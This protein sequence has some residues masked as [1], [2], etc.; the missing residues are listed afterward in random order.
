MACVIRGLI[1]DGIVTVCP[2]R[3]SRMVIDCPSWDRQ[4]T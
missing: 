4:R 2:V 3:G 1:G